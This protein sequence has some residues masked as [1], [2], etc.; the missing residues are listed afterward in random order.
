VPGYVLVGPWSSRSGPVPWGLLTP[1]QASGIITGQIPIYL[2]PNPLGD[3]VDFAPTAGLVAEMNAA[4]D[5]YVHKLQG[6]FDQVTANTEG[7]LVQV[8]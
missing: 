2:S 5:E 3:P 6:L 7:V 4:R 8:I 1:A